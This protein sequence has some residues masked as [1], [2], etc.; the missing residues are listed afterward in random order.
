MMDSKDA[1]IGQIFARTADIKNAQVF[2]FAPPMIMGYGVSNG[3]EIYV[4]DRKGGSVEDLSKY[5]NQFIAALQKRP[6]IQS[7]TTTFNTRF[8]QYMVEVDAAKCLRAEVEPSDVLSV[9]SGYIGGNYVSNINRFS[10]LYRVMIQASTENRVDLQ[11]LNNMYVR[12]SSGNMMPIGQFIKLTKVYGPE[13]LTRFNLF[14]A[15]PVNASPADGYSS[16]D[17]I[18]AVKEVASQTLPSGYSYEYSGISR[19][20]ASSGSSTVIIFVICLVFVYII[21]CSLYESFFIPLAVML[22]I[23]FGLLGSFLFAKIFGIENNIYMQTGLIMLIG[24]ISKTAILLT[25]YASDRRKAGMSI[26]QSAMSAATVRLRPILMTAICMIV[27]MLPLVF[28]TGAGANGDKSLGVGV[29]GGMLIGTVALLII[30]PVFFI[31]F[32]TVE[33]RVMPH[34][35]LSLN[36]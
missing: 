33:E 12:S 23:P 9:M 34:R 22:S 4:Q 8:P 21:L 17:A 36:E 13:I 30:T 26:V 15:I 1:V 27:G 19:D 20:E 5:T 16:G 10:K 24:L 7:A 35:D 11:S 6:E 3:L 31:F 18:E 14:G 29:V 32:Q 28:A 25:E 2:A